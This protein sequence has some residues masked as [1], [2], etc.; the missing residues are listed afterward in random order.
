MSGGSDRGT[1]G[2][3]ASWPGWLGACDLRAF[4]PLCILGFRPIY[5]LQPSPELCHLLLLCP[6]LKPLLCFPLAEATPFICKS[7]PG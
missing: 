7:E 2:Q 3:A 5:I 1:G 6:A 4:P